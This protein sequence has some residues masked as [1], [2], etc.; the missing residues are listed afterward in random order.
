MN[1]TDFCSL[2]DLEEAD[3]ALLSTYE[4]DPIFFEHRLLHTKA[5]A[6]ARRIVIFVDYGRYM[7]L[8]LN[9]EP[10]RY[11][12]ERYLVVPIQKPGGVFH[13]KLSLLLFQSGASVLCGSNNLTQAGCTYNLELLNAI[14][15]D[16]EEGKPLPPELKLVIE[17]VNFFRLSIDLA[18]GHAGAIAEKWIEELQTSFPW[19]LVDEKDIEG[20]PIVQLVHSFQG[21]LW[22]WLEASLGGAKPT[23]LFILSPFYDSDLKL[24]KKVKRM[25]PECTVEITAQQRTSNL[26]IQCLK[27][28][29][30]DVKL[31][32]L[33]GAGGRRLHA[34]LIAAVVEEKVKCLYGSANFTTAA[35]DGTN[36]EVCFGQE[37]K[38]AALRK[39]F[40]K[41]LSRKRIKA[42]DFEPGTEQPPAEYEEEPADIR[43][44][45]ATLD[46]KGKLII[47]YKINTKQ[48]LESL[49]LAI[50]RFREEKPIRSFALSLNKSETA[51]I[52]LDENTLREL[53]GAIRCYLL[54]SVEEKQIISAPC[55][56]VQES[57][58]TYV[59][60]KE[61]VESEAQRIITE[62]GRGLTEH[63]ESIWKNE[64]V[65]AVI[66]Y[67]E[68]LS[69]RFYDG[70]TRFP[71]SYPPPIRP[72]DPS[73][74]DDVAD[75]ALMLNEK[76]RKTLE[77]AYYDFTDRQHHGILQRHAKRGNINGLRNFMDVF[78]TICRMMYKGYKDRILKPLFAMERICRCV[79]SLT[80]GYQFAE[81]RLDGYFISIMNAQKGNKKL[82]KDA[83][84][85]VNALG[86]LKV[87][88]LMAQE[89]RWREGAKSESSPNALLPKEADKVRRVLGELEMSLS[90]DQI[91]KA[92]DEYAL[93]D[94]NSRKEWLSSFED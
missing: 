84:S 62:T 36:I 59:P 76:E 60:S 69:I 94:E 86:H 66:E 70:V 4:F 85:E 24:L 78:I 93:F 9:D 50:K 55:W 91:E 18:M 88:L 11:F 81:E 65:K 80:E 40:D 8:M 52:N 19:L 26:W 16:I 44:L 43:L 82:V 5:L 3:I 68:N 49:V 38:T 34:K 92:L 79:Y 58:L 21:P 48:P 45:S 31:F 28:L 13:P 29:G 37:I 33:D 22:T 1:Y 57:R 72:R 10:A 89:I 77:Q 67:L 39:L 61:K 42:E 75:W 63:L 20:E 46:Q 64:G 2:F 27:K 71:R 6:E 41:D 87:A 56:L 73:R 7:K 47:H 53:H 14:H 32:D 12:N 35:L 23:K 90:I 25:W 15:M 54:A 51:T 17:A 83:L 30:K 74:S